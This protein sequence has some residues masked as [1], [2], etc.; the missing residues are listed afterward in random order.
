MKR[1]GFS[2]FL[3][4]SLV[5]S[6]LPAANAVVTPGA[7]CPKAGTMQTYNGKTYTCVKLGSKLYWNNGTKVTTAVP[8]S[9]LAIFGI[10]GN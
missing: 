2:L 1:L 9:K 4:L 5:V 7:K 8:S 3:A 10:A 6:A